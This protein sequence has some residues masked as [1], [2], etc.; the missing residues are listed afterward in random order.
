MRLLLLSVLGP[1]LASAATPLDLGTRWELFIDDYL[2]AKKVDPLKLHEPVRH[3]IVLTTAPTNPGKDRPAATSPPLGCEKGR[4]YY[5]GS[6]GGSDHSDAQVTCFVESEDGIH[7]TRPKLGLIEAGG[8]KDNNVI[9][10]GVSRTTSRR[11]SMRI[12]MRSLRNATRPS[13]A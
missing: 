5:R 12:R 13:A 11:F 10:R 7:F 2:V 1:L 6:A 9:W 8:T 4:L 3:E